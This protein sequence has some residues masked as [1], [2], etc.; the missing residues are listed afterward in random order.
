[1]ARSAPGPGVKRGGREP[2]GTG[3]SVTPAS[4]APL[5]P[6]RSRSG[7][8]TAP[9]AAV[10]ARG[11]EAAGAPAA[12][13]PAARPRVPRQPPAGPRAGTTATSDTPLQPE[14]AAF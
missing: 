11:S 10:G 1:M 14:P 2:G 3:R 7:A 6:D 9:G 5:V 12:G 8:Q 13:Q 4:P